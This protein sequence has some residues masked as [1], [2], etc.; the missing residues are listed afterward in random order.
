MSQQIS[1]CWCEHSLSIHILKICDYTL[2]ISKFLWLLVSRL[3]Y[4]I[5]C[6]EYTISEW[7]VI[8]NSIALEII[9]IVAECTSHWIVKLVR[10]TLIVKFPLQF[11]QFFQ[12]LF[13]GPVNFVVSSI[14]FVSSNS[15][16]SSLT[17]PTF[18][19]R[20]MHI[21]IAAITETINRKADIANIMLDGWSSGLGFTVVLFPPKRKIKYILICLLI[22]N[23]ADIVL[24]HDIK[25][26]P[27]MV[28]Y[29]LRHFDLCLG[30]DTL[31]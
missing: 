29:I 9:T 11:V 19:W 7:I 4:L 20:I 3:P 18:L 14:L 23:I 6:T 22:I 8:K 17:A 2:N 30:M 13:R 21:N 10:L 28:C 5:H 31:I 15:I 1:F 12:K 26:Q 25:K 24:T 27:I 16:S